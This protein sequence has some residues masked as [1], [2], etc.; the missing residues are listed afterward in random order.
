M[1]K[2]LKYMNQLNNLKNRV[3]S[4]ERKKQ[5]ELTYILDMARNL[6]CTGEV[7]GRTFELKVI[8]A[9]YANRIINW[10]LRKKSPIKYSLRQKPIKLA[11]LNIL[12]K[13]HIELLKLDAEREQA[14]WGK[15][16][17]WSKK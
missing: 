15:S 16:K 2:E 13:E 11:Q 7:I 17:K 12:L 5:T 1:R 3:L 9:E 10:L 6:N 14:K 4:K 8:E